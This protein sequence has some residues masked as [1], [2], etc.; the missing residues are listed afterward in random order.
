MCQ[1]TVYL[2]EQEIASEVIVLEQV[3]QTIRIA[4]FFDEPQ[5]VVGRIRKID[6]LKN[7]VFIETAEVQGN[8]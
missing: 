3:E 7:E 4:T 2:D 6:L 5:V 1:A 8:G